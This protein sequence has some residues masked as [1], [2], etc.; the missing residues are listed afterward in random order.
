MGMNVPRKALQKEFA[1]LTLCAKRWK[2]DS[3][4][5]AYREINRKCE[6]PAMERDRCGE[7]QTACAG[8]TARLAEIRRRTAGRGS[9][10]S[11]ELLDETRRGQAEPFAA[12]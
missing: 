3:P 11:A 1:A 2:T 10:P 5:G 12:Q 6:M 9:P 4:F 8:A 7:H